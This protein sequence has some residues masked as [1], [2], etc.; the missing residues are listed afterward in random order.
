MS[1]PARC[2]LVLACAFAGCAGPRP[3]PSA[4]VV[5]DAPAAWQG[6]GGSAALQAQW[7]KGFGDPVLERH[8]ERALVQ[9]TD[10]RIAKARVAEARALSAAQHGA[11]LPSI[12]FGAGA[13]RGKAI[14]D[15]TGKPYLATNWQAMFQASYEVDLWGRLEALSAASDAALAANEAARDATTLAVAA[16]TASAYINLRAL[17]ERLAIAR[18]T[19]EARR[20]A[21]RVA[22]ARRDSGHSS[23]FELAQAEAEYRATAQAVPQLELAL[24]RLE[25]VLHVLLGEV[26]AQVERGSDLRSLAAPALPAVGLPSS[27]LRR[28]PDIAV[29]EAQI[30]GSDA[31][32]GAA[33]AQLLPSVR[34]AASFGNA[35]SSV[36]RGDPFTLWTIGGSV[37]A[38]IFN[39]GRLRAQVDASVSRRDQALIGYRKV[40]LIAFTEVEDQLAAIDH[41]QQQSVQAEAQRAAVAEA[42]RI[43][44]NRYREGYASYLEEL[45][46]QRALYTA[47]Q[48]VAQLRA[49][50]LTAHVNLYRALGG[51]WGGS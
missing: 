39:G 26:P 21:L 33:R 45:D 44:R 30:V 22:Q 42:L 3:I 13:A 46:A 41:L 11:E 5:H 17:D 36:L 4:P 43:A 14:S 2:L 20:S 12:D 9:N 1:V 25:N 38:P 34:L 48:T 19:L 16:S 40:V 23:A 50:L 28:R 47:E 51:G 29:A 7:W 18:R 8:V 24:Q 10:L 32:L 15:V 37:L 49:D 27:L 6:R 35:G 31:Q